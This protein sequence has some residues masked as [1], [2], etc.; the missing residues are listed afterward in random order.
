MQIK[1]KEMTLGK[2][3]N[4][5]QIACD[6]YGSVRAD[7]SQLCLEAALQCIR[8]HVDDMDVNSEDHLPKE[9]LN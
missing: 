8:T 5:F 3:V 6:T 2:H 9:S 4:L 7:L 1:T